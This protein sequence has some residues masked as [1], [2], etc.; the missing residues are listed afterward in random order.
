MVTTI[1]TLEKSFY[2][3][4]LRFKSQGSVSWDKPQLC[5]WNRPVSPESLSECWLQ[6]QLQSVRKLLCEL[7]LTW[8]SA[9]IM[10]TLSQISSWA[11]SNVS[12]WVQVFCNHTKH[13]KTTWEAG[14]FKGS[15]SVHELSFPFSIKTS[16][17][18]VHSNKSNSTLMNHA[19]SD[20]QGIR[21]CAC[22]QMLLYYCRWANGSHDWSVVKH[23]LGFGQ[24]AGVCL[25]TTV[26]VT[27][28]EEADRLDMSGSVSGW[29]H[30]VWS[31]KAAP[32][33]EHTHTVTHCHGFLWQLQT[34]SQCIWWPD[35]SRKKGRNQHSKAKTGIKLS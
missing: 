3:T 27:Q 23:W 15:L 29:G 11:T 32:T 28:S 13:W 33:H 22:F 14:K 6:M 17:T 7:P 2:S 34:N 10:F 8:L 16:V 18:Q 26:S 24:R 5:Q 19:E 12:S 35:P 20:Y 25:G 31:W 4:C 30:Y 1:K 21:H 9:I